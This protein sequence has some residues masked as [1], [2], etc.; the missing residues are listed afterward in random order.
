MEKAQSD[1]LSEKWRS[2]KKNQERMEY[3]IYDEKK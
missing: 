3:P 1:I 2:I